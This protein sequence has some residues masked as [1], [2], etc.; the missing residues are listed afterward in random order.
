VNR[1]ETPRDDGGNPPAHVRPVHGHLGGVLV[2]DVER[3]K[4]EHD[5][6]CVRTRR[7]REEA[8]VDATD[9]LEARERRRVK[10]DAIRLLNARTQ[11]R[12]LGG[13]DL[14]DHPPRN[15]STK[16]WDD[17]GPPL[18]QKRDDGACGSRTHDLWFTR[19]TLYQL[20]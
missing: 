14:F 16:D 12:L 19:P 10:V 17:H 11:R 1:R 18:H 3:G 8:N 13:P 4:G 5:E 7:L 15:A 9:A 6:H 2:Q 20:S